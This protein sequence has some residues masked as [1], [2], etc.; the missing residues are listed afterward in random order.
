MNRNLLLLKIKNNK[1]PV[2]VPSQENQT[3][4]LIQPN[5]KFN[6]DVKAKFNENNGERRKQIKPSDFKL[7]D[8]ITEQKS[9]NLP[10]DKLEKEREKQ[11]LTLNPQK[12]K[13]KINFT[14]NINIETQTQQKESTNEF[15]QQEKEKLN[16]QKND[17]E[18]ILKRYQK[19]V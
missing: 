15:Y 19:I 7:P 9:K 8:V 11:Q 12:P 17:L 3:Q 10:I 4:N 1:L 13:R 18:N 16:Q 5:D 14:P 6:P 2:K